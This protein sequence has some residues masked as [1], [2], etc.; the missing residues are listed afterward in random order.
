MNLIRSQPNSRIG[1]LSRFLQSCE[2]TCLGEADPLRERLLTAS[3]CR[4]RLNPE[5]VGVVSSRCRNTSLGSGGCVGIVASGE[6]RAGASSAIGQTSAVHGVAGARVEYSC[7]GPRSRCLA[8]VGDELDTRLQDVSQRCRGRL[9]PAAGS[10][11]THPERRCVSSSSPR[12]FTI[13]TP[14]S[15]AVTSSTDRTS[16]V[17]SSGAAPVSSLAPPAFKATARQR[18]SGA[19]ANTSTET[20]F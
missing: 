5:Q 7:R 3:P 11:R 12:P 19:V 20:L 14:T 9:R 16:S 10:T 18:L 4:L 8:I 13:P 6:E 1:C 2:N 17:G 15:T